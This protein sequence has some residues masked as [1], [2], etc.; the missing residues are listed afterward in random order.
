[1]T[2]L[3][4]VHENAVIM[5]NMHKFEGNVKSRAVVTKFKQ[6]NKSTRQAFLL[7]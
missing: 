7:H 2:W 4:T 6:K 3:Y 5:V 1:M